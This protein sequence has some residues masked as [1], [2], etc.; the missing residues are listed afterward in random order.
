MKSV[1]VLLG[2]LSIL[3][4]PTP[5]T[6][7]T[8][9]TAAPGTA[10]GK[11]AA[12]EQPAVPAER[13]TP[14]VAVVLKN[15]NACD[16][17]RDGRLSPEEIDRVVL[18]RSVTGDD[19][20]AAGT[21]KLICRRDDKLALTRDYFERYGRQRLQTALPA[22]ETAEL[23]TVDLLNQDQQ[24]VGR[25]VKTGPSDWDVYFAGARH[26][27]ARAA[28]GWTGRFNVD[29]MRQGPLSD[30]FLVS[31][32]G[33]LVLQ[34]PAQ[35]KALITP[36]PDG[37]FRFEPPG[38]ARLVIKQPTEAELAISSVSADDGPWLA[39]MEEAFSQYRAQH[40]HMDDAEATDLISHGGVTGPT[41]DVLTGNSHKSIALPVTAERRKA[42][43]AQVLPVLRTELEAA[44]R[45]H[46]LMTVSV[47]D[48]EG[49]IAK[50]DDHGT[51]P[52]L[53]PGINKKHAY[54]VV[55]YDR[56]RDLV[57]VW[58]PHGQE[59]SP[60]GEPGLA[61]GYRTEHGRFTLPLTEAYTFCGNFTFETP[62]PH[63]SS[64]PGPKSSSKPSPK[65]SPKPSGRT[66]R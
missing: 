25:S 20:A 2:V 17:N 34:R 29:H 13:Q 62:K 66:S 28:G 41:M 7:I 40:K 38:Q 26:R 21:L 55:S 52:H 36:L 59:F 9:N 5:W 53:P 8:V 39:V 22:D 23:E 56:G 3:A 15:W 14:F 10:Q 4:F 19:A 49:K 42:Q 50:G 46:R 27:I 63:S 6:T 47:G 24:S 43:A 48:Y 16:R 58:N 37:T 1:E 54:A 12:N 30:C 33:S 51:A 35:L 11:R 61:N 18:D 32:L 65:S 45:E 44:L 31:T 57:V 60:K 64:T